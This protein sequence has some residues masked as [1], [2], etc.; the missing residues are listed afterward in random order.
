MF[1][2]ADP[3]RDGTVTVCAAL[4]AS[5]KSW[6]LAVGDPSD[7]SRTGI[8]RLK[9]H[10]AGGLPAKP[11]QARERASASGGARALP[12]RKAGCEGVW[13]ARRPEG[14]DPEV[15][16]RGPAG[17]EAVRRKR[18]AKADRTGARRTVRAPPSRDGGGL[19]AMPPVRVPAVAE[20]DA[21][22][23]MRRRGRPVKERRRLADTV[24]GLPMPHGISPG[25]P[26]RKGGPGAA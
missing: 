16:A 25:G 12:V 26:A 13:P 20:E 3:S 9:P 22:R 21:K 1:D 18:N 17:L 23:L 14:G 6:I 10:G 11:G 24:A 15:A 8:R 5:G 4:E 19:D 2:P 7:A